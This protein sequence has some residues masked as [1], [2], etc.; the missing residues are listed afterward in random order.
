MNKAFDMEK[1]ISF[2][3]YIY[4]FFILNLL[5]LLSNLPFLG[6]FFLVGISRIGEYLPLF[7]VCLLPMGPSLCALF[8]CM[9][10]LIKNKDLYPVRSY[11]K[12][13]FNNFKQAAVIAAMQA[14]CAFIICASMRF[15]KEIPGFSAFSIIL[16]IQ[17]ALLLLV[18]PFLYLLIS[19]YQMKIIEI[20]KASAVIVIG[21]PLYAI[22]NAVIFLFVLMLFEMIAGTTFLFIGSA[23]AFLIALTNKT[24]FSKLES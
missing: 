19:R 14:G 10:K 21:K 7:L 24:L 20:I 16:F 18:T 13:Y 12:G 23:Y 15:F 8:Y 22:G 3:N 9:N 1:I 2:F 17:L 6:F 4:Y 11:F 5:F